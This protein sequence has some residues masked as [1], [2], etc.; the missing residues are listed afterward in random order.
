MTSSTS[1]VQ[2]ST[3]TSVAVLLLLIAICYGIA[4]LGAIVSPGIASA[5]WYRGIAKPSWTLPNWLFG[6][7][8][9]TL[10]TLMAVAMWL[11]WR[12]ATWVDAPEAYAWFAAQLALNLGWSWLFFYFHALFIATVEILLLIL[13][14]T[15][16]IRSFAKVSK[17]ASYLLW[18]YLAWV[19]FATALCASVWWMN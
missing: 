11:V 7:V 19:S 17:W 18:P 3:G 1:S 13:A 12:K 14:I 9:S 6:P 15:M 5:E 8:W 10:Y 2:R 16:T 4:Y